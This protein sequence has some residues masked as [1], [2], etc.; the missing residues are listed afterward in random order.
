MNS[1]IT[2]IANDPP[3]T[4]AP[5]WTFGSSDALLAAGSLVCAL[6]ICLPVALHYRG[7]AGSRDR[8]RLAAHGRCRQ[9]TSTLEHAEGRKIA[10]TQLRRG[11]ERYVADVE[12]RPI[13]PWTSAVRELSERRPN[14]LWTVR[15]SGN[16]ARFRAQVAAAR[17]DLPAAYIN[18]LRQSSQVDYAGLPVD[19]TVATASAAP[20]QVVG[21]LVGE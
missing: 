14:G 21:R 13:V 17:A 7:Q 1:P 15:L 12:A 4:D 3:A 11:V 20:F 9:L 5:A 10:L 19:G 8:E 16:G 6:A 18:S 2:H